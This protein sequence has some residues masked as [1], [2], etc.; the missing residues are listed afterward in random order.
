MTTKSVST[1][2]IPEVAAFLEVRQRIEDLKKQYP[3]IFEELE[4]LA[5][6]HNTLLEAADKVVRSQKVSCGPFD[7]YQFQAKYHPEALYDAVGREEFLKLGGSIQT[8]QQLDIDKKA[9][10]G[11]VA[12]NKIPK[13]LAEKVKT[14]DPR[15]HKPDKIIVP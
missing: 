9:F 15:Y 8:I 5:E 3:G 11:F 1:E 10:D 7:L 6:Q 4:E 14:S 2:D 12:Q 13:D